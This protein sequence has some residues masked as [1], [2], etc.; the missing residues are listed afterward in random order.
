MTGKISPNKLSKMMSLFFQGYSQTYIANKLKMSQPAVSLHVSQF[1]YLTEQQGLQAASKEFD[2]M[3]EVQAL[4]SLASELKQAKLTAEEAKVGLKMVRLFQKSGVK[5]EDYADFI[6]ACEKMKDEGYIADAVKLNKLEKSTG[7]A[8]GELLSQY[9][10]THE[11]MVKEGQ[12]LN[13]TTG[14]HNTVKGELA[15]IEKLKK[16]MSQSLNAYMH[17]IGV[18]MNRLKL[19]ENLAQTL[20]EAGISNKELKDYIAHQ[21]VLNK[22]GI[23]IG[24]LTAILQKAKVLTSDD[25]GKGLLKSLSDYDGIN[26]V[27]KDLQTKVVLLEKQVEGLEKQAQLKG[28]LQ[29]EITKLKDEKDS[30][31]N[32]VDGLHTKK[33]ELNQIQSSIDS[34]TKKKVELGEEIAK[35]ELHKSALIE[36]IKAMEQKVSDLSQLETKRDAVLA[37]LA[38][39]EA[40]KKLEVIEREVFESFLGIVGSSISLEATEKFAAKEPQLLALAKIKNYPPDLLRYLMIKELTGRT[41][42]ILR[43]SSCEA[44]FNVEKPE[45][46]WYTSQG[47]CCPI[48][49]NSATV[50]M[51][52]TGPEIIQKALAALTPK[53]IVATPVTS[54]KGVPQKTLGQPTSH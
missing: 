22:A 19:V 42:E 28:E 15:T 2:V 7:M 5:E 13:I 18:D 45:K 27:I 11:M 29:V 6:Q 17:Q 8:H 16:E 43:C 37:A 33:D 48:C 41:L 49:G 54:P 12:A 10:S 26:K 3:D 23:N 25:Q 38:E 34:F 20:K 53:I 44:R 40:K 24:I 31:E 14:K 32:Y 30:L 51:D 21:Q 50:E 47:Y 4:R 39:F 35:Q 36:D 52:V 9:A 1:K 46:V